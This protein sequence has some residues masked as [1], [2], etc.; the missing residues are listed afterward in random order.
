MFAENKEIGFTP[1]SF[2]FTYYGT[3]ELTLVKDG[4]ET[5]TVYPEVRKPWY[6]YFPI[7]FV[8]DNFSPVKINNRHEFNY[9]LQPQVILPNDEILIR[10]WELRNAAQI[11]DY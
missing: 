8:A 7:E 5:L 2:D 10:G 11:P 4:Y 9:Q 1:V 6:Q 3:R